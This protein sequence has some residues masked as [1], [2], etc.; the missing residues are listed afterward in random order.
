MVTLYE[1]NCCEAKRIHWAIS[2]ELDNVIVRL[3][4]FHRAKNFLGVIGKRTTESGVEDLWIESDICG[5]NV[6]TKII[7]A[8]H[9][10]RAI[11]AHKLTL[12]AMERLQLNGWRKMEKWMRKK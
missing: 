2:P 11:S 3:G 1:G 9:C 5:R 8:T 12:G 4:G 7:S 6:A 10:N